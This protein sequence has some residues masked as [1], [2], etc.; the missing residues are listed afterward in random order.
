MPKAFPLLDMEFDIFMAAWDKNIL[1]T[2]NF[3]K[4][5]FYNEEKA[6]L[7]CNFEYSETCFSHYK[8]YSKLLI[9]LE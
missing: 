4:K 1:F 6:S 5:V 8:Q 7:I 9:S 2:E 3:D